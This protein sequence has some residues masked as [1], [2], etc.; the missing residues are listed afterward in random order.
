MDYFY[1]PFGVCWYF[2]ELGN[3]KI[4]VCDE[5]KL[6]TFYT[7][8]YIYAFQPSSLHRKL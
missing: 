8:L 5:N 2:F 6:Y 1:G 7:T 3:N 4:S